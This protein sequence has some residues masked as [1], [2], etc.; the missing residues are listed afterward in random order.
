M[1]G[2]TTIGCAQLRVGQSKYYVWYH[3]STP[4]RVFFASLVYETEEHVGGRATA[5]RH[6]SGAS[7]CQK[8]SAAFYGGSDTEVGSE[9]RDGKSDRRLRNVKS[10]SWR[11]YAS[12]CRVFLENNLGRIGTYNYFVSVEEGYPN[13]VVRDYRCVVELTRCSLFWTAAFMANSFALQGS[14]K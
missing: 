10:A 5:T 3:L 14:A 8:K 2:N 1:I 13:H 7:M 9:S 11:R 4:V 12:R 6:G